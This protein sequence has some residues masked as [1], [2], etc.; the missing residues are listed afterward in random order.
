MRTAGGGARSV[1]WCRIR[2]S[3]LDTPV[4]RVK[5]AGTA[6]G[7]A[8]LAASGSVHPDL[9]AAAAAMVPDGELVEPVR[10]EVSQLDDSYQRFVDEL[11]VRGW[12]SAPV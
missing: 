6:L 11:T 4:L 5:G 2:A 8:L 1:A 3:V 10:A 12:I 9:S 7:A